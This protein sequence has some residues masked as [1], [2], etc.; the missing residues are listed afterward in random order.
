MIHTPP[1]HDQTSELRV[2]LVGQTGLDAALRR[3]PA[4]EL[5]RSRSPLDAIGELADPIDDTSPTRS[6]VILA[7]ESDRQGA[8]PVQVRQFIDGLRLID[9]HVRILGIRPAAGAAGPESALFDAELSRD[10]SAEDLL[11]VIRG[12]PAPRLALVRP[13]QETKAPPPEATARFPGPK[14]SVA[15]APAPVEPDAHLLERK[16]ALLG[17]GDEH[18][19]A[20]VIRGRDPRPLALDL[21]RA[22]LGGRAVT[23]HDPGS[24][25]RQGVAAVPVRWGEHD[26][27]ALAADGV[28]AADLQRH[29]DWLAAWLRL[30]AQHA[31]LRDA[32]YRDPLTG[33]WNRR[34]FDRFM[35]AALARSRDG[36]HNLTLLVFDIDDFKIYNDKYGHT[37]G[38]EILIETVRLLQSTVRPTDRVCRIGGDE[39]A[40]VFYEPT[41]PRVTGSRH[42]TSF[43]D[44]ARRFQKQVW[45][46]RYPKL[47]CEAPGTLTISGGLATFPW[48]GSTPQA[49]LER[50][51]QLALDSKRLGKNAIT[52]GPG[53]M[54]ACNGGDRPKA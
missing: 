4:I 32:A 37:A 10:D 45:E 28:P 54:R 11:A 24:A 52:L 25:P 44:I 31:E 16:P 48:D 17:I 47:G 53:A 51:D 22:R 26:F 15:D 35:S 7:P 14:A 39:F 43:F 18:L 9:P 13:P 6:V 40:V 12:R 36:R 50:A 29:A 3:D 46:H 27:G 23:L 41:G 21:L 1:E 33:A 2:I 42:P 49:L 30:G 19:A 20:D 38:D 8:D 5:I 34:Y